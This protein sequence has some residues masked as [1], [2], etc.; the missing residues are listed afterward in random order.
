[1]PAALLS[2]P[3]A[4]NDAGTVEALPRQ[5]RPERR[6]TARRVED[7]PTPLSLDALRLNSLGRI[8]ARLTRADWRGEAAEAPT[9]FVCGESAAKGFTDAAYRRHLC[10]PCA[11]TLYF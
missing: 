11:R 9:C 2:C 8:D 7:Q 3:P 4:T 10:A 5:S 1:M 6:T